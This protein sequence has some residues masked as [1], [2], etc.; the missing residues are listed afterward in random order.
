M[1]NTHT[2][3]FYIYD[4]YIANTVDSDANRLSGKYVRMLQSSSNYHIK[5]VVYYIYSC[6]NNK[7]ATKFAL[8]MSNKI[9]KIELS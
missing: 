3:I 8:N 6:I 7:R 4:I 2:N 9:P 5:T 1:P